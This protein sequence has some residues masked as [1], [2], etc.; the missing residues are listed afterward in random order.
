MDTEKAK[1]NNRPFDKYA[2]FNLCVYPWILDASNKSEIMRY[3]SKYTKDKEI[4]NSFFNVNI[5]NMLQNN[6]A[7][8]ALDDLN[9]YLVLKVHR[10]NIMYDAL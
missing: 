10:E 5:M 8:G 9:P 3:C 4:N 7:G 1:K 6:N 2:S